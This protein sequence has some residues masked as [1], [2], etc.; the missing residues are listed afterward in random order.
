MNEQLQKEGRLSLQQF[1]NTLLISLEI[2]L[3]NAEPEIRSICVDRFSLQV[4]AVFSRIQQACS[5]TM[6]HGMLCQMLKATHAG[7]QP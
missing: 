5:Y 2:N 1:L 7:I 4:L 6:S 3:V